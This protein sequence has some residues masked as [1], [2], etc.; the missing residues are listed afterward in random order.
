MRF[1]TDMAFCAAFWVCLPAAIPGAIPTGVTLQTAFGTDGRNRLSR[2]IGMVE[3][4]GPSNH[5]GRFLVAEQYLG[6]LTLLAPAGDTG[7]AKT[8]FA[9]IPV[10]VLPEGGLLGIALHPAFAANRKYYVVYV[11]PSGSRRLVVEEREAA[12]DL[13]KDSGHPPRI[14]ME[15]PQRAAAE[16][17][18]ARGLAFGPDGMLYRSVGEGGGVDSATGLDDPYRNGQSLADLEADILRIDVRP[19]G[20][21]NGYQVPADN[22]FAGRADARGEVWAYGFRNPWRLSFDALTGDLWVG[23]VGEQAAEEVDLVRKGGNFGWSVMEGNGCYP[24]WGKGCKADG[25]TPPLLAFRRDSAQCVIG[26]YVFRGDPASAFNGVYV[27]ADYTAR[28]LWGLTQKDRK[29]AE[30][31]TLAENVP[32][33]LS[34][35]VDGRGLLYLLGEDGIIR[36]L[37]HPQMLAG[38]AARLR[39]TPGSHAGYPRAVPEGGGWYALSLPAA[40]GADA[41][42][43][44]IDGERIPSQ[45]APSGGLR[46]R[47]H[48]GPHILA[49]KRQGSRERMLA[50]LP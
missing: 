45:P 40:Y 20:K 25:M 17:H 1:A 27:F 6:A 48:R 18:N 9:K 33:M 41:E 44:A 50:I 30:L 4:P 15:V 8:P 13:R 28:R 37:A 39:G 5:S 11:P 29:L 23:D 14:V 31:Q 7:Y 36:R 46:V 3:L 12:A 21:G 16:Y 2:P 38:N 42:I 43:F 47:A 22:P 26:G 10:K 49:V 19:D 34:L 32:A 35:A 24:P